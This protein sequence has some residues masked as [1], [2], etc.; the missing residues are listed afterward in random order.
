VRSLL[1]LGY[2]EEAESF[3]NWLLLATRLT[4]PRLRILYNVFGENSPRERSLNHLSGYLG[5]R[6]VRVGNAARDQIQ[7]DVYGEVLDAV[8]HFVQSGGELDRTLQKVLISFGKEVVESWRQPD[9]GIWEP[10][11]GRRQN[12]Y[13]K[14]MCWTGL[15]RLVRLCEGGHLRKAPTDLFRRE[16]ERIRSTV[17]ECGWNDHLE[18]Y[19]SVL[20][21]DELDAT[22]LLLPWYGFEAADSARMKSTYRHVLEGLGAG[23]GLLYRYRRNPPEGAFGVCSFWLAEYLAL[24]GASLAEACQAFEA[25]LQYRNDLG[26]FA[27]EMAPATGEALGNFPQG[28]THV[29]VIS[30]A[31]AIEVRAAREKGELL[32]A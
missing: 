29:G 22:L 31:L 27:E 12:T 32:A 6:P 28:F 19:V 26:L 13:S 2:R 20:H 10:R 21:G 11:S 30:A 16:R 24:G 4:H 7:L 5:S 23:K 9:E 15:D 25:A 3:L 17:S 14:L 18:S 1:G 8:W